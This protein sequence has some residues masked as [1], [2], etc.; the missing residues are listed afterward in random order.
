MKAAKEDL[1]GRLGVPEAAITVVSASGVD[2]PNSGLGSAKPDR[3]VL[4]V[5]TP[6][7]REEGTQRLPNRLPI[8]A[9]WS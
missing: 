2:W 7:N 3:V 8:H 5:I 4:T 1:A 9:R 6:K